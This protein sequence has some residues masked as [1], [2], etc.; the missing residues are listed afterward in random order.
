ME[1]RDMLHHREKK[2]QVLI[3]TLVILLAMSITIAACFTI[4][5]RYSNN[6]KGRLEKLSA[7]VYKDVNP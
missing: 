3:L 2:A 7:E 6:L 1:V 4:V 5:S